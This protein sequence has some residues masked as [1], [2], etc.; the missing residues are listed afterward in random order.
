LDVRL[1]VL[2]MTQSLRQHG[3][4]TTLRNGF[5][6]LTRGHALDAFDVRHGTDTSGVEPL[7][8]FQI[9]SPNARFG[10][11]YEATDEK[12]LVEVLDSLHVDLRGFTFID[13]GCG[14][15]RTLLVAST[16][17]F[18]QVIG[19]EF[20]VELVEIARRNLVR[21]RIANGVVVHGDAAD[22]E[23]PCR[24]LIVY[25]FNP[26]SREVAQRVVA[27]LRDSHARRLYVIY[28]NPEF[29]EVFDSS[30]FLSRVGSPSTRWSIQIWAGDR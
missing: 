18:K 17:D 12:E 4:T 19:V 1:L 9:R 26:F 6:H 24:D 10:M 11:R 14:K 5:V 22:F 23:F 3:L 21:M 20:A 30:G 16:L 27:R 25:L 13:L 7:W 8:S 2:K 29:R 15:G 28:K